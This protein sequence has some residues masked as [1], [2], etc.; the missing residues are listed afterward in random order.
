MNA[1]DGWIPPLMNPE[2]GSRIK[3][4][5]NG[6]FL[7]GSELDR[8]EWRREQLTASYPQATAIDLEGQSELVS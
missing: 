7:I 1:S 5:N 6:E 3:V 2:S 4:H 8:A